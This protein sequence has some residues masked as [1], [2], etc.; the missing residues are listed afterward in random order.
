V[1][2]LYVALGLLAVFDHD[3]YN[4]ADLNVDFPVSG[5]KLFEWY[6]PFGFISEI[7][8]YV[9]TG[10]SQDCPLQD[11]VSGGWGEMAIVIEKILVV[12]G[13]HLIHLPVVVV[14]GH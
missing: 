12:F 6:E 4:V 14:Y 9:L 2:E 13:D 8:D 7:D 3:V 10:N 1:R 5:L 11:F